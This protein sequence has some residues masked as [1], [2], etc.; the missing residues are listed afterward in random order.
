MKLPPGGR[1]G[2]GAPCTCSSCARF[3]WVAVRPPD[4]QAEDMAVTIE[5]AQTMRADGVPVAELK[6]NYGNYIDELEKAKLE[7][8]ARRS[9]ASDGPTVSEAQDN[10]VTGGN[11]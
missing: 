9:N 4:G 7:A 10:D 1:F 3:T 5:N 11:D 2:G 8:E 6:Q